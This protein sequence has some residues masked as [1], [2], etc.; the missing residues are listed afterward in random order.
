[1]VIRLTFSIPMKRIKEYARRVIEMPPVPDYLSK[2]GPF[3]DDGKGAANQIVMMYE[4]EKSKLPEA[5]QYV[6]KHLDAFHGVPGFAFSAYLLEERKE[7]KEFQI[8]LEE[9]KQVY[10]VHDA[11]DIDL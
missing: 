9:T 2:R 8:D 4:C 1:M 6:F 3:V 11:G 5:C 10:A 7:A